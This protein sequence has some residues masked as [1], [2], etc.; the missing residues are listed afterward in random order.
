MME[1]KVERI[2]KYHE[3]LE[4]RAPEWEHW[5]R[6]SAIGHNFFLM[7][8]A[9]DGTEWT[10]PRNGEWIVRWPNSP[11]PTTPSRRILELRGMTVAQGV[12]G[13]C[14]A[15]IQFLDEFAGEVRKAL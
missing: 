12:E 15:I 4:I 14:V 5:N 13:T 8:L 7:A 9:E 2:E 6:V 3:G 10:K 11:G 1:V